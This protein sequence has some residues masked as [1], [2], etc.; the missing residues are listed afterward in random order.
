MELPPTR[1]RSAATGQ[2][3]TLNLH[4]SLLME[5]F[6]SI[7]DLSPSREGTLWAVEGTHLSI[8]CRNRRR[9]TVDFYLGIQVCVFNSFPLSVWVSFFFCSSCFLHHHS[10]EQLMPG[11]LMLSPMTSWWLPALTYGYCIEF[12]VPSRPSVIIKLDGCNGPSHDC[13]EEIY[14]FNHLLMSSS[15]C[16]HHCV[17]F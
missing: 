16:G 13:D 9:V 8:W 3:T 11:S 10:I 5:T 7:T 4:L 1:L 12:T 14:L 2:T 17:A 6:S 15:W